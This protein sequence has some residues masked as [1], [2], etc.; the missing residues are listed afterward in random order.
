MRRRHRPVEHPRR[1]S[2]PFTIWWSRGARSVVAPESCPHSR[3]STSRR[4]SKK[5]KG[6]F[7]FGPGFEIR[8]DDDE[9]IFQFHNLTQFEYR[10]YQQCGQTPVKDSFL[11]PRQWFMFSGRITKPIGYFVSL[12]N[13]F[14][15][16]AMLDVFLDLEYDPRFRLRARPIQDAVHLRV[17]R[18]ADP[19]PD[20]ARAVALL[21][22]LRPEP[23]PRRH[24][25]R[26]AVQQHAS[27]T[28]RASSTAT[29]TASSATSDSKFIS[30]FV[31]WKPFNNAE[32]SL[33]ENFNIGGSVFGG[34]E[35][36]V[37]VP[38]DPPDHRADRG[39]RGRRRAVPGASTTTS[40]SLGC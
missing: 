31:N 18:R 8:T 11:F 40:G 13:G 37:P 23:R 38:A 35:Y 20:P 39:Q 7:K 15:T 14:D 2:H 12:A 3:A 10:G 30:S 1:P 28:R 36:Q 27:T 16:I 4:R 21:Q 22:Q 6:N 5:P 17:L 25:L 29:A 24:G 33:L 26:P 32:G 19:G 34:N 9:Y